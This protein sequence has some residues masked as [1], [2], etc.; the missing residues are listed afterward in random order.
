VGIRGE[1]I[2]GLREVEDEHVVVATETE[3]SRALG[4]FFLSGLPYA[5]RIAWEETV[6]ISTNAIPDECGSSFHAQLTTAQA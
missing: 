2:K 3:D 6:F 1:E 4:E 5:V